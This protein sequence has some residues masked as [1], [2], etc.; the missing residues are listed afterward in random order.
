[1]TRVP[2]KVAIT[3]L[4]TPPRTLEKARTGRW[5]GRVRRY[6]VRSL[7]Y[8][9]RHTS[10]PDWNA[11]TIAVMRFEP[12]AMKRKEFAAWQV[13]SRPKVAA[14]TKMAIAKCANL[15]ATRKA[16]ENRIRTVNK[17]NSRS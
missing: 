5:T 16:P 7:I 8:F 13:T 12:G 1:M 14:V 17:M 10:L 9:S 3:L 2:G 6:D 4:T 11:A 15:N